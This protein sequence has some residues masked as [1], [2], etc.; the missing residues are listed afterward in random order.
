MEAVTARAARYS[1]SLEYEK[2]F[3]LYKKRP[4]RMMASDMYPSVVL[5]FILSVDLP[6]L[7][8]MRHFS[9]FQ[10][11]C[12]YDSGRPQSELGNF[13]ISKQGASF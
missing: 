2:W 4:Y 3:F 10:P 12:C 13:L 7:S 11:G 8:F 5:E 6:L 1:Q 9:F